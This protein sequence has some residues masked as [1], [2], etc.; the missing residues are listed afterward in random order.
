MKLS[1]L[2]KAE[3]LEMMRKRQA[4]FSAVAEEYTSFADF[5]RTEDWWL[6]IMGIELTEQGNYLVLHI[7]L[8]YTDYEDYFVFKL[9]DSTLTVSD[10]I[11]WH[12]GY[13][14]N[15]YLNIETGEHADEKDI[16]QCY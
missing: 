12:D 2:P 13:C 14:C 7:Q 9:D 6:A 1:E 3:R 11:Q 15:S 16:P 8:D 5:I 10:V 4:Y